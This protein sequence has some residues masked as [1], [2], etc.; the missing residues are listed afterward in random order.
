MNTQEIYKLANE[1]TAQQILNVESYW[2]QK[3]HTKKLNQYDTLVRLGDSSALAM[4]TVILGDDSDNS[5]LYR[6]AYEA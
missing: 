6:K 4:A 1:L 2:S 3:N 5:E